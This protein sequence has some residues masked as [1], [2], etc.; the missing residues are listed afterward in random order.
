[1][2]KYYYIEPNGMIDMIMGKEL[3]MWD[4]T[5]KGESLITPFMGEPKKYKDIIAIKADDEYA[6]MEN[7]PKNLKT[8]KKQLLEY[9]G[10]KEFKESMIKISYHLGDGYITNYGEVVITEPSKQLLERENK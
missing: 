7:T 9:I 5:F 4:K 1:M 6:Y 10:V 3:K 2:K 8:Y